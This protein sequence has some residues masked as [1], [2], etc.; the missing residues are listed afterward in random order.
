MSRINEKLGIKAA[1]ARKRMDSLSGVQCPNCPHRDVI[2]SFTSGRLIWCC[3]WCGNV[4]TPSPADV[5]AYNARVW[6]RDR[7]EVR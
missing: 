4:W 3:G 5:A 2:S 6:D 7:I 1:G